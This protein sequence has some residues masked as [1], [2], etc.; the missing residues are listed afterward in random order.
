MKRKNLKRA[1]S[2]ESCDSVTGS[3]IQVLQVEVAWL[4][5]ENHLRRLCRNV[6]I[7]LEICAKPF[8]RQNE[9]FNSGI[10]PW[11][12]LVTIG[13]LELELGFTSSYILTDDKQTSELLY[14]PLSLSCFRW[15]ERHH[16][17]LAEW[18][19]CIEFGKRF[20][21]FAS[22]RKSWTAS[23]PRLYEYDLSL[24]PLPPPWISPCVRYTT[25]IMSRSVTTIN[26]PPY[27]SP[28]LC[29]TIRTT[30][31]AFYPNTSAK[32]KSAIVMVSQ[33]S[34]T[35]VKCFSR[36]KLFWQDRSRSHYA[37][38]YSLQVFHPQTPVTTAIGRCISQNTHG[39]VSRDIIRCC[40]Q[41]KFGMTVEAI[42][43][44]IVKKCKKCAWF[45]C[46]WKIGAKCPKDSVRKFISSAATHSSVYHPKNWQYFPPYVPKTP[47]IRDS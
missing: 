35:L 5:L 21:L 44:I 40:P 36:L 42:V 8:M 20:T 24:F 26:A 13:D 17:H 30:N 47:F 4:S 29:F 23:S 3:E 28:S 25:C 34:S 7:L 22:C 18:G 2:T 9:S 10:R 14:I 41:V 11:S 16:C 27:Y 39:S 43:T 6:V 15:K 19:R 31:A 37:F 33:P 38:T 32:L 1:H 46:G 45:L 12:C